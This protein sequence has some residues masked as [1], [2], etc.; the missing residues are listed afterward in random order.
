MISPQTVSRLRQHA[1]LEGPDSSVPTVSSCMP[2]NGRSEQ[3]GAAVADFLDS[4]SRLNHELNG[5]VPAEIVDTSDT[6]IPRSVAY[7][8]AEVARM[9]RR[10]GETEREAHTVD[11]VWLAVLAGDTDDVREHLNEEG[12]AL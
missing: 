2:E 4:L 5:D 9:L 8:V 7:S 6:T 10:S 3:L 11:T 1:G 12:A